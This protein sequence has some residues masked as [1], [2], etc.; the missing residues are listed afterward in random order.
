[1]EAQAKLTMAEKWSGNYPEK[2]LPAN[3]T[4]LLKE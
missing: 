2:I 1:M 3:S 4:I